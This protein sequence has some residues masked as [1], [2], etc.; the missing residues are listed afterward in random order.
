[1]KASKLVL[2][3]M[4]R[5]GAISAFADGT[6]GGFEYL[7]AGALLLARWY[8]P[9]RTASKNAVEVVSN[10]TRTLLHNAITDRGF[11][12]DNFKLVLD[13]SYTILFVI[14]PFAIVFRTQR[15]EILP[16]MGKRGMANIM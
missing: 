11:S 8:L 5:M 2:G 7:V 1:M 6:E 4:C 12:L 16:C 15:H 9:S 10:E 3:I 13:D 14:I